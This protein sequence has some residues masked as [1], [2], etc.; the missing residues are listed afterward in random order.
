MLAIVYVYFDWGEGGLGNTVWLRLH[1]YNVKLVAMV[2]V[3]SGWAEGGFQ[4]HILVKVAKL[5]C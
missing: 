2:L 3:Y 4:E 1:N 5:Q